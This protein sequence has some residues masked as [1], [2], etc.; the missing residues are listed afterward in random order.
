M[1]LY[2]TSTSND[3]FVVYPELQYALL[4]SAD[5]YVE[6]IGNASL[7]FG[8]FEEVSATVAKRLTKAAVALKEKLGNPTDI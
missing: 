7:G 5:Q 6:L 4:R 1:H 2:C 3:S 8:S